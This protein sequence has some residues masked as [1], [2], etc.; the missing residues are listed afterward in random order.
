MNIPRKI[1]ALKRD[2]HRHEEEIERVAKLKKAKDE[3]VLA[4]PQFV[5]QYLADIR[6]GIAELKAE[7]RKLESENRVT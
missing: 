6:V 7:I 3:F 4:L 1:A 2:L 5:D